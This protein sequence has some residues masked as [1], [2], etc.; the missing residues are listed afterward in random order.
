MMLVFGGAHH[1]ALAQN[2]SKW[3]TLQRAPQQG[4]GG[5]VLE[6]VKEVQLITNQFSAEFS[7]T[8]Y[9]IRFATDPTGSGNVQGNCNTRGCQAVRPGAHNTERGEFINHIDFSLARTFTFGEDRLEFRADV[10]NFTNNPN[11]TAD[12][13]VSVVGNPNFGK[14]LGGSAVFPNRQFQFAATYRF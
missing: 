12:G 8:P 2:H 6:T 11:L 13:Y 9:S 10:F 7:G 1:A 14:H 4:S 5:F 3:L